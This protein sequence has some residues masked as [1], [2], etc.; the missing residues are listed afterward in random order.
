MSGAQKLLGTECKF[1]LQLASSSFFATWWNGREVLFLEPNSCD[2]CGVMRPVRSL[3]QSTR[4]CPACAKSWRAIPDGP[5]LFLLSRESAT[6]SWDRVRNNL[7]SPGR[8]GNSHTC[9]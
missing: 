7:P 5:S 1:I 9:G 6:N 4:M 2:R 3:V 8:L